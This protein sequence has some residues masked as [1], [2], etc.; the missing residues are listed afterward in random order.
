MNCWKEVGNAGSVNDV[1]WSE[2]QNARQTFYQRQEK[3]YKELD[4]AR[5]RRKN[6]NRKSFQKPDPLHNMLRIGIMYMS[7]WKNC[8]TS[9]SKLARQETTRMIGFGQNFRI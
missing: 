1:L 2:F 5:S 6:R 8:W 7:V 9:G 3:H 4:E